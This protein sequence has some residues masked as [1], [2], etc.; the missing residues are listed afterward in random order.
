[1]YVYV[2]DNGF[3]RCGAGMLGDCSNSGQV[4]NILRSLEQMKG[5]AGNI[6]P[7]VNGAPFDITAQVRINSAYLFFHPPNLGVKTD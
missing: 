7:L 3:N 5:C 2:G 4:A 1:M 6:P